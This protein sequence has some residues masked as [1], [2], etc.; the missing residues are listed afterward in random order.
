[1]K[2]ILGIIA[3]VA[4][5]ALG[6]PAGAE[7]GL[8]DV[9]KGRSGS[10]EIDVGGTGAMPG[11]QHEMMGK[12]EVQGT[13]LRS[14]S[15]S[16]TINWNGAAVPFEISK[17]TTFTGVKSAKEVKE[18]QEVRA[19]FEMRDNKNQLRS[20][21]VIAAERLPSETGPE[22]LPGTGGTGLEEKPLY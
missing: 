20:L 5:L 14:D 6:A 4:L 19:S 18:G 12:Q 13:V 15:K 7:G 22:K 16:V 10:S 2:R 9:E 11:V 8:T 1:M 3:G 21:E 17:L